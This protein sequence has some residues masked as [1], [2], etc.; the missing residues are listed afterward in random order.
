MKDNH[1][2]PSVGYKEVN[3][4]EIHVVQKYTFEGS[5]HE[6]VIVGGKPYFLRMKTAEQKAEL[7]DRLELPDGTIL[8][9]PKESQYL[10]KP[11]K[12]DSLS[13]IQNW[14]R[15]N[16]DFDIDD[17]FDLV[18]QQI[19]LYVD[20]PKEQKIIYAADTIFTYFQD[21][22]GST[23][24]L[25][26]YGDNDSGKTSDN[27]V[28]ESMMYRPLRT[29]GVTTA[30][31]Y[32]YL[33]EF[34]DGQGTIIEDEADDIDKKEDKMRIYK[35]GYKKGTKIPRMDISNG[36]NQH[37]YFTF[38][39]KV[40]A[41]E[42]QL[43][44]LEAKGLNDRI[45]YLRCF[46]GKPKHYI[47]DVL[48]NA[49]DSKQEEMKKELDSVRNML[50]LFRLAHYN[51]SFPNVQTNIT[52]RNRELAISLIKLFNDTKVLEE[53]IL[54]TLSKMLTDKQERKI[55]SLEARLF[56][57]VLERIEATTGGEVLSKDLWES[58]KSATEGEPDKNNPTA[59]ITTEF[60]RVTQS[61]VAS[62][63]K[64]RFGA[65]KVHTEEGNG[66][67]FNPSELE[68]LRPNYDA[69]KPIEIKILA[70]QEEDELASLHDTAAFAV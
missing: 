28:F 37:A 35:V 2:I 18:M 67:I 11:Y 42:R 61:K 15:S 53:A 7:V 3:E 60:G 66:F 8:V 70:K 20:R 5:L 65:K 22:L 50:F 27:D 23:H 21:R 32:Q 51:D 1:T 39:F 17:M 58:F 54:P 25:F 49:G 29:S 41:A 44:S 43:N 69:S 33:G 10:N 26:L 52:N 30:N 14:I 59:Y 9:P 24:Y 56:G 12:F 45:F 40:F 13:A 34:E 68:K 46:P 36:R 57:I 47:K 19:E 4:G 16:N 48:D 62:I 31:I 55:E 64:D 38:G 63:L 6:A